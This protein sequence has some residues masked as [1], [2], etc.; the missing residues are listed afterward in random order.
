MAVFG[1][2]KEQTIQFNETKARWRMQHYQGNSQIIGQSKSYIF[3]LPSTMGGGNSYGDSRAA[4]PFSNI[5]LH[6]FRPQQNVMHAMLHLEGR[7]LD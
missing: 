4:S 2:T 1:T 7:D 6:A 3:S 5:H